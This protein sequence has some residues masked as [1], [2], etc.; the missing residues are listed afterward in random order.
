M[1]NKADILKDIAKTE[2]KMYFAKAI[3]KAYMAEKTYEP[4][5]TYFTDPVTA[6]EFLR[7]IE[8]N[9]GMR[10]VLF[11]GYEGAERVM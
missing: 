1:I 10:I 9:T 2:T 7:V 3:D 5:F 6:G 11:G 4:A 8:K